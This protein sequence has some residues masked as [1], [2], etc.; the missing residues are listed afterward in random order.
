MGTLIQ[1]VV[2]LIAAG[3]GSVTIA[4]VAVLVARHFRFILRILGMNTENWDISEK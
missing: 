2:D 1:P 4:F 3:C